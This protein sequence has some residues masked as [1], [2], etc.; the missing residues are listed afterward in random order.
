M[1]RSGGTS[2]GLRYGD[3]SQVLLQDI[4]VA[5]PCTNRSGFTIEQVWSNMEQHVMEGNPARCDGTHVVIPIINAMI[6]DQISDIEVLAYGGNTGLLR[7]EFYDST[8]TPVSHSTFNPLE[9][10]TD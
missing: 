10:C 8:S 7:L 4:N 3:R 9:S 5:T 1:S 6:R 2:V